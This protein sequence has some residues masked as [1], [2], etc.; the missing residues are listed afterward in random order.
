[1]IAGLRSFPLLDGFRGRPR[2]DLAA[3]RDAL[4]RIGALAAQHPAVA[5]LDCDPLIAGPAGVTI[6]DA[7]AAGAAPARA[8]LHRAAPRRLTR[9]PRPAPPASG[10]AGCSTA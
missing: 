4:L 1:M 5:E 3:V 7:R 6:V 2:A 8:A 10:P 9:P